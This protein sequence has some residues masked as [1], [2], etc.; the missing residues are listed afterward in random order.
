MKKN[1]WSEEKSKKLNLYCAT[2]WRKTYC[3]LELHV[4][5]QNEI[6]AFLMLFALNGALGTRKRK[7]TFFLPAVYKVILSD[8]NCHNHYNPRFFRSFP[9]PFI[10]IDITKNEF[11]SP[12]I[13]LQN[14]NHKLLLF[15]I[16]STEG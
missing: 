10:Q 9:S 4:C 12:F 14:N 8:S 6:F 1:V 7:F 16:I 15:R 11:L 2:L 13:F 3:T 5:E